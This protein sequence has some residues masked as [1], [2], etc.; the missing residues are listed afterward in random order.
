M[1]S[2][3]RPADL[4]ESILDAAALLRKGDVLIHPTETLY[5]FAASAAIGSAVRRVDHIKGRKP[6]ES[7]LLLIRDADMARAHRITFDRTAEKLADRFWPGPLT[8]VLPAEAGASLSSLGRQGTLAVR[9]SSD[10]FVQ[11]LF[12]HIDFPIIS[13][14]VNKSGEKPLTDPLLME[15]RFGRSVDL[16]LSRGV[17][18]E[19]PPSTLVAVRD[20][21]MTVLR[22]GAITEEA[23]YAL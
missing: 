1:T 11:A 12:R 4:P 9:V 14:S 18:R 22:Q 20:N 17:A 23:L 10:P 2:K 3:I 21:A 6:E 16:I 5:G 15:A 19:S 13:T 8:L 7:Y